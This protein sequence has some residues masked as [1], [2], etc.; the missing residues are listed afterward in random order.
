MAT[1]MYRIAFGLAALTVAGGAFAQAPRST[2]TPTR[3]AASSIR[4]GPPPAT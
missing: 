1:L 2:A 3:T 4:T